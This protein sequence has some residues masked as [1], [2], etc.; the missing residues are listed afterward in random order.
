MAPEGPRRFF[1][2]APLLVA[3]LVLGIAL[4]SARWATADRRA[5]GDAFWYA[6][7]AEIIAGRSSDEA[8]EVAA[9]V[10][11]RYRGQAAERWLEAPD[12]V[13][14]R[15][16]AIFAARPFF[17]AVAAQFARPLGADALVG[18]SLLG[19]AVLAAVVTFAAA[20][21]VGGGPAAVFVAALAF[22]LPSGVFVAR[23]GPE[24]WVLVWWTAAL[25]LATAYL[26]RPRHGVLVGLVVTV[27]ALYL[28]KSSNA[29][30]L[31][32]A[33]TGTAGVAW[34][35]RLP[36]APSMARAAVVVV[37]TVGG[38][39]AASA[40]AG[41]PSIVDSIQDL[42]TDHFTRPD[43]AAPLIELVLVDLRQLPRWLAGLLLAPVEVGLAVIAAIALVRFA[44]PPSWPWLAGAGAT[45]L[46]VVV[47]PVTSE[48]PR[49][50]AP[51]WVTVA[52]GLLVAGR[53]AL[54]RVAAR[55]TVTA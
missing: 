10:M 15:Y 30:V 8:T 45:V 23:L 48:I 33:L 27:I 52:I 47:H 41:Q 54:V 36:E 4:W 38:L 40:A 39:L 53:Q 19:G 22:V 16:Q 3:A 29:A 2:A 55:E 25:A 12:T 35:R 42:L 13:D 5:T 34:W 9:D 49:L 18:A 14:P 11:E 32:I 46:L 1:S 26:P 28:T 51:I 6:R 37:A 31:A 7:T 20:R 21:F 24:G 17:P 43:V 44:G 50:L